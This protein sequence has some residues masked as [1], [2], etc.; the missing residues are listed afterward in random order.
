[1]VENYLELELPMLEGETIGIESLKLRYAERFPNER[2]DK[3]SIYVCSLW[4]QFSLVA[5]FLLVSS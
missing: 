5:V 4:Y 3:A 1:M 2:E